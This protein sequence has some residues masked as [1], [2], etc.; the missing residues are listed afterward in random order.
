MLF[1]LCS[2]FNGFDLLAGGKS[3]NM[4]HLKIQSIKGLSGFFFLLNIT[5]TIQR[6]SVQMNTQ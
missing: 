5:L 4:V 2:I 1:F 6:N 3:S